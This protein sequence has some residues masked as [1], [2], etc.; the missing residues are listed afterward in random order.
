MAQF[1]SASRQDATKE[2]AR[3]AERID[4]LCAA[5]LA[6]GNTYLLSRLGLELGK[7]VQFLKLLTGGGL[8]DFIRTEPTLKKF[9]LV[10]VVGSSNVLAIVHR[11]DAEQSVE[12]AN[13]QVAAPPPP[14]SHARYHYRFWAAFSV[15]KSEGFRFLDPVQ[16]VFKDV[17]APEEAPAGWYLIVQEYIA[18]PGGEDRDELIK[19]NIERWLAANKLDKARFLQNAKTAV[20]AQRSLLSMIIDTLDRRQLQST[21]MTLDVIAALENKKL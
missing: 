15:S 8:A 16:F 13:I 12:T 19:Q 5:A 7:D 3:I 6:R 17:H 1:E 21:T 14:T 18:P 2:I 11:G 20:T 10:P 9:E 4:Q